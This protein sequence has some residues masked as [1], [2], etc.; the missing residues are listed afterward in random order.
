MFEDM[1][2]ESDRKI[3]EEKIRGRDEKEER[4]RERE[5]ELMREEEGEERAIEIEVA[6][7]PHYFLCIL[8]LISI[9]ILFLFYSILVPQGR[10]HI[11]RS[12]SCFEQ[13]DRPW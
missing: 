6:L 4:E 9:L 2:R 8:K 10:G 7:F 11:S 5:R 3:G 12:I 13:S 1:C